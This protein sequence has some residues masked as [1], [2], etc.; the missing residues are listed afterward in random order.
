MPPFTVSQAQAVVP[1][2]QKE[3]AVLLPSYNS[4]KTLWG[5]TSLALGKDPDDPE[6][7]SSC[8]ND[9][10]AHRAL[11]QIESSLSFFG[12]LGVECRGIEDG[13]FEFPCLVLNRLVLLCW[14]MHDE[15]IAYWR[16][17]N[18]EYSKRRPLIELAPLEVQDE[19]LEVVN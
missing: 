4:L 14:Q 16:E 12:E 18:V 13:L 5:E 9:A 15:K 2:L 6:V 7:R 10:R 17:L 19:F 11:L 8:L 3:M 1:L